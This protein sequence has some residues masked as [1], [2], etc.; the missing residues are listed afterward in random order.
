M[1]YLL[2]ICAATVFS[3]ASCGELEMEG[4]TNNLLVPVTVQNIFTNNCTGCHAGSSSPEGMDLSENYAYEA[5][6]N[7]SS[8]QAALK[9][10]EPGQPDNSYLVRKIQ[11][12]AG[13]DGDRMPADGPP[14]LTTAQIDTIRLWI[15]NGALPR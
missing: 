3:L 6:V 11:G 12:T 10:V 5:I 2:M 15:T 7:V 8:Q 1:R 9:R 14:Y 13:I 4:S